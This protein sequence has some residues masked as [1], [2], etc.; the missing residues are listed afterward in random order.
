MLGLEERDAGGECSRNLAAQAQANYEQF[1]HHGLCARL[2][3]SFKLQGQASQWG[4]SVEWVE[5][6]E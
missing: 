2:L 4:A 1:M 5:D 3:K 6:P